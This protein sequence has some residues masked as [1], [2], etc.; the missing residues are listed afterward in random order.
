VTVPDTLRY[1]ARIGLSEAPPVDLGGLE[2]LQRAHLTAVPFENL[3]VYARSGVQT[4]LDWSLPKIVERHRGGWCFELN[5]AFSSLLTALG[6]EV[7]RL[8]AI[9][10]LPPVSN[11]PSHLT[12]EVTLDLPYLVDV[13]FGDTFIKPLRLDLDARQD[14]GSG[15]F[16]I[17]TDGQVRTLFEVEDGGSL[18]AQYRFGRTDWAMED[19]DAASERLQ[20]EPGLSWT[21]SRFATR[22]LGGGPDRVTLLSDRIKFRRDGE[23]R[24]EPIAAD[25]WAGTLEHWFEMIP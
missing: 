10:L 19:F 25:E 24:E 17:G 8:G 15:E 6:F 1:L 9:V 7:R 18:M 5:G 22:L 4:G 20:S 23:W 21:E 16:V 14:G 11:E 3:D 13:G 12:L 2:T